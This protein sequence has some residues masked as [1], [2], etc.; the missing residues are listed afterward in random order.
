MGRPVKHNLQYFPLDVTFFEN[1]KTL[2]IEEDCGVKGGYLAIRLMAMVYEKGYFLE[3]KEKFEFTCAKRVGNGYTG[4][5]VLEILRSC[6]RHGLFDK[7]LFEKYKIITSGGIQEVWL[8][9]HRDLR[10]KIEYD[11]KFWLINEEEKP[12]S[13]EETP[14]SHEETLPSGAESTQKESKG[15][16][17]RGN[18][19]NTTSPQKTTIH[20]K[21]SVVPENPARPKKKLN[22]KSEDV[23]DVEPFWDLL[24][25]VW[26]GFNIE[27]FQEQPSFEDAD[28][29]YLKKI[30]GKLKKRALAK[31]VEWNDTSA[32]LRLRTFFDRAYSEDWLKKHF[33][34]KNLNEQFDT[35]ILN[36]REKSKENKPAESVSLKSNVQ[37]TEDAINYL[38]ERY[39]EGELDESL[40]NPEYYDWLMLNNRIPSKQ[41]H[42]FPGNTI[43]EQK[44]NGII[45][46]FKTKIELAN[47][48]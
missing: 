33:L 14:V 27:K 3:W 6:L 16:E 46:Y 20:K 19:T 24:V 30:V 39:R 9:V 34:L 29:R 44:R 17:I 25:E 35:I 37:K 32:P 36:Q 26:F 15:N 4:A 8:K 41:L 18:E 28:P 42:L 7:G 10:R 40:I 12:V 23:K 43:D 11:Q 1:H 22:E 13:S 45:H 31:K 38:M 5:L 48:S 47:A 2:L 21:L